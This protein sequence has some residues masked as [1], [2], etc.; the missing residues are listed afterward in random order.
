MPLNNGYYENIFI[1]QNFNKNEIREVLI[2]NAT[3]LNRP[4]PTP[5]PGSDK[6]LLYFDVDSNRIIVW[7]GYQ[8]HPVTYYDD[9][10]FF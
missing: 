10:D 1:H 3:V 8:W 7:D 5:S 9:R 2:H 6:G 4:T